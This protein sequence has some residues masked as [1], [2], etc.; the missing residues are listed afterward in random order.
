MRLS[1]D[2]GR[3]LGP[4]DREPRIKS[5]RRLGDWRG[6]LRRHPD[7]VDV[8]ESHKVVEAER[9]RLQATGRY[10]GKAELLVREEAGIDEA[11]SVPANATLKSTELGFP[12]ISAR[13]PFDWNQT[14]TS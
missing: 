8:V 13:G 10:R 9:Q 7:I 12:L 2:G 5:V 14:L 4:R 1:C 3:S 11:D 6:T